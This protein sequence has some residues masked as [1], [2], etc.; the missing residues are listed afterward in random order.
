ALAP[1][2]GDHRPAGAGPDLTE[3]GL[4]A[5]EDVVEDARP[6]GL[7][8]ELRPEPDEPPGRHQVLDADPAV[9]VV[10][11]LLHPALAGG[12]QLRHRPEMVLGNED[13][14]PLHWLAELPVDLPGDD[15]RLAD[16]QLE[17]L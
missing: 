12:Q 16:G 4:V 9:A 7:G 8:H 1:A 10:D 11:Q 5:L 15:L 14:H 6:P 3:P 17:A 13:R 2:I